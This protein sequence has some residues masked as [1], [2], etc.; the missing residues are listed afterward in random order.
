MA[1]T[2]VAQA[3][4]IAISPVLTRLFSPEN[5][6]LF[7][8][9]F[10]ISQIIS[11]FITGRYEN[12]IILPEKDEEAVNVVALSLAITLLV[13]GISMV[14]ALFVKYFLP[15]HLN[16]PDIIN[17]L[18][19]MPVT[20]FAMG[21]SSIF[22]LWLNRKKQYKNISEGKIARSVF[23]SF[24]SVGF[25]LL[26]IKAGGL[27]IADTIGQLFSGIYVFKKS[28]K[29][30]KDKVSFISRKNILS[31][32]R[33]YK[34]FP[35]YNLLSGLLEKGSGHFPVIFLSS[36][37][38][39]AI[40]GFFSLSQRLIAAPEILI[41]V[42]VGNVFRQQANV[43]YLQKGNCKEIFMKLFKLLLV[44]GIVPFTL[45][46]ILAPFLFSFI[47]GSEWRVAGEYTQ[48]LTAMFFLSFV[49][50]PLSNMF[51]IAEKQKIDL[52]IQVILFLFVCISFIVGYKIFN[53]PKV[54]ILLYSAI[55]SI[56]YFLEFY[57]SY[58]FS[59]GIQP[60]R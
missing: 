29:T 45:L 2:I 38:G 47:F 12:A 55:Y 28:L 26:T 54:A 35:R 18:F 14:L 11:V 42:S 53:H 21:L 30:D 8:L 34:Q 4:P 17:Y 3:I 56:K 15:L 50:S 16:N 25:G 31:T 44:I 40:T 46:F 22:T 58:Q 43:I 41:S 10:S 51:F 57:L 6:G 27:I 7:A 39:S 20:V 37:F 13:S 60:E 19:L 33:R 23:S 48:I 1:G 36:F 32:A 9:Y 49:V 24:F 59:K 5:F 52:I